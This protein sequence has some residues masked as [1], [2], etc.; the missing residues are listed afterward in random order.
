[1]NNASYKEKPQVAAF[2]DFYVEN[3]AKI[4]EAAKFITLNDEQR[5]E[6]EKSAAGLAG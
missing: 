3:D 2:V 5:A 1:M 4:S 6:L